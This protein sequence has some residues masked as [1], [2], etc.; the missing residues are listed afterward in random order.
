MSRRIFILLAGFFVCVVASANVNRHLEL[1]W[2]PTWEYQPATL[3]NNVWYLQARERTG[4]RI[5]QV[6]R[7]T[8]VD[9]SNKEDQL[10]SASV[11]E[12]VGKLAQASSSDVH[13]FSNGAGYYF[14]MR[15]LMHGDAQE[16][17][18][19]VEGVLV[20]D[21]HLIYFTLQTNDAGTPSSASMLAALEN[22]RVR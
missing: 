2:P 20:R 3:K 19:Q 15:D 7:M 5:D 16:F 13:A 21:G 11:R 17:A 9:A 10:N 4:E 12:L 1:P 8:I 22:A 18:Q 6:L 14:L